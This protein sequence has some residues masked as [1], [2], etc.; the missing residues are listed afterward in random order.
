MPRFNKLQ[1]RAKSVFWYTN[2]PTKQNDD[3]L[4]GSILLAFFITMPYNIKK[5]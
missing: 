3:E 5:G 2:V 1:R 4:N